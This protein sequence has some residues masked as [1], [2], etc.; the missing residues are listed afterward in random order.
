GWLKAPRSGGRFEPTKDYPYYEPDPPPPEQ[1]VKAFELSEGTVQVALDAYCSLN[2]HLEWRQTNGT[3]WLWR[4]AGCAPMLNK[5]LALCLDEYSLSPQGFEDRRGD[6]PPLIRYQ[7]QLMKQVNSAVGHRVFGFGIHVAEGYK[8]GVS[9][10]FFSQEPVGGRSFF[11][12]EHATV[13]DILLETIDPFPNFILQ[14]TGNDRACSAWLSM[15][16][17][18]R[19]QLSLKQL[20][21]GYTLQPKPLFGCANVTARRDVALRELRRR[22]HFEPEKVVK[23]LI[24]QGTIEALVRPM[25]ADEVYPPTSQTLAGLFQ[26]NDP[27]L[28][29]HA[30]QVILNLPDPEARYYYVADSLPRPYEIG[31]DLVLPVWKRLASDENSSS[32]TLA[33]MILMWHKKRPARL[34]SAMKGREGQR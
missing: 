15:W 16:A 30:A 22:H 33:R 9:R 5:I 3:V 2:P 28:S 27:L 7:Y 6:N 24:E 26:M 1:R 31:F 34:E 21:L 32:R 11:Q 17:R 4:K 18:R 13:K 19:R 29:K 10:T 14:L 8:P 23:A 25:D 12:R 20:A